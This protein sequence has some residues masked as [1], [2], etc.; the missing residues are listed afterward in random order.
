MKDQVTVHI[1]SDPTSFRKCLV[2][3]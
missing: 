1:D 3:L 2:S